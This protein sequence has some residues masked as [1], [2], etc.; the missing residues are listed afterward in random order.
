MDIYPT[1]A[2]NHIAVEQTQTMSPEEIVASMKLPT[3]QADYG[4]IRQLVLENLAAF[5]SSESDIGNF[6]QWKADL[7]VDGTAPPHSQN[8]SQHLKNKQRSW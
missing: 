7:H 2:N 8:S 4:A 1:A 6:N 5:S 3:A